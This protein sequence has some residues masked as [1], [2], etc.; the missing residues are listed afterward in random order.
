MNTFV[1]YL[2]LNKSYYNVPKDEIG[3]VLGSLGLYTEIGVMVCDVLV[4]L[5]LDLVGRRS[6]IILGFLITGVSII[7]MPYGNS[8]FPYLC[9]F[10]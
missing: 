2:L 1:S 6:M 4:G 9:V 5:L 8:V 7:A 10:K 3:N